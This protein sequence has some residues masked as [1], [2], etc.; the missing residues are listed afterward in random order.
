MNRVM[1]NIIEKYSNILGRNALVFFSVLLVMFLFSS[2]IFFNDFKKDSIEEAKKDYKLNVDYIQ[3]KLEKYLINNKYKEIE[4]TL[5]TNFER[6][7]FKSIEIEFNKF[8][9]NRNTLL[10]KTNQF[11]ERSWNLGD[12][13]IDAKYGYIQKV[14]NSM[15]YEYIPNDLEN[16]TSTIPIRF[17]AYKKSKIKIFLTNLS[18][19]NIEKISQVDTKYKV[20]DWFDN[21][22]DL[23]NETIIYDLV[24]DGI[25]Y[26]KVTYNVD[27]SF[28]KCQLY[29][30]FI[31][32]V[33]FTLLLF[34]PIFITSRFYHKLI[35][36]KY[37]NEPVKSLNDYLEK[38][39]DNK[40]EVLDKK[41]FSGTKELRELTKKVIKM[42]TKVA[43][44]VNE[45]N[46]SKDNLDRKSSTDVLTGLPNKSVF[47][48]DVKSMFVT[49]QKATIFTIKLECLGL[50]SKNHNSNYINNFIDEYTSIIKNV[51]HKYSKMEISL[52]RFYGSEFAIIV[53]DIKIETIEEMLNE[54]I[55]ELIKVIPSSYDVPENIIH[56]GGTPFDLF[57]SIDS[58][59]ASAN[60]AFDISKTKGINTY[61]IIDDSELKEGYDVLHKNVMTIIEESKFN[62]NYVLDTYLF[63]DENELFMKEAVPLLLDENNERLSIGPFLSI[64]EKLNL[65]DNFDKQVIEKTI[66]FIKENKVSYEIAINLSMDSINNINFM[67][68]LKE[69][70]QEN[71]DIS[72]NLVFSITAYS[73]Y[74]NKTL[75]ETFTKDV[76]S[77][78]VKTLIKRYK[79]EEYPLE[80]LDGIPIDYIRMHKDYTANFTTDVA[81]KHKVKN[82]LIYGELNNIDII[83]DSVK[84]DV[85]YNL[86]E[87]LGAYGTSK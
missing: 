77:Y 20:Y 39:I 56:I 44:L 45:L 34:V 27:T 2:Y 19:K 78:G 37:V 59:L 29:N 36:R 46:I 9:F 5:N 51:I 84:L 6:N 67:N 79:I 32:L 63:D 83:A 49:S 21:L 42:S 86:L 38:I 53:K 81:K 17:Q 28:I 72:R 68:W 11:Q 52:Y 40:F 55:S 7:F 85:D 71:K 66:Q 41:E 54:M 4:D 74:L 12:I 10:E 15:L 60:K 65:V 3:L 24:T 25:T 33:L 50:M 62:I 16:Y 13:V 73:A 70:L 75:F 43:S 47:D 8:V 22:I 76:H 30:L 58:V 69:L 87:R 82:V 64:A 31:K 35:F 1:K 14:K 26:G 23:E 18:F 57:G 80:Q 61:H 48:F